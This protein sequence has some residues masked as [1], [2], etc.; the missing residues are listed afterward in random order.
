MIVPAPLPVTLIALTVA[1]TEKAWSF[2]APVYIL[3][4]AMLT[5][6]QFD[7][8]RRLA[9]RL[10]GI[11]LLERHRELLQRRCRRVAIMNPADLDALLCAAENG[12][13]AAGRRFVGLVTTKFTGFF[14]HPWHFEIAARQAAEA[15]RRRGRAR[16]WSAGAAT[17]EEPYSLAMALLESLQRDDPPIHIL[18][19]D[20]DEDALTIAE[21]GQYGEAALGALKSEQRARFFSEATRTTQWLLAPEARRLVDFRAL[22]LIDPVW[23]IEGP[24]DVI[25]CRNVLM[26]LEADCRLVVLERMATLLAPEGLLIL[27]PVEHPGPAG[28]LFAPGQNGTY[29]L[30]PIS[31]TSA[32]EGRPSTHRLKT[33]SL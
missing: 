4:T 32:R 26:Y 11:E 22:N 1:F 24:F 12:D 2:S 25:F 9:L 23:P 18:A 13:P 14:R 15:V 29:S 16:L 17:G 5:G 31:P 28:Q 6:E 21:R 8:T 10:A 33:P 27:D 30:R 7:R 3:C 20:L 19:T